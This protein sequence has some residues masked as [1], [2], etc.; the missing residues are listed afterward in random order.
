MCLLPGSGAV[1]NVCKQQR[2][3]SA[4]PRSRVGF[5][6][7]LSESNGF[8]STS[9]LGK[10]CIAAGLNES[11]GFAHGWRPADVITVNYDDAQI[12]SFGC[13]VVRAVGLVLLARPTAGRVFRQ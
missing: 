8:D 2:K 4:W 9:K 1:L 12:N 5:S 6:D 10:V 11:Q 3:A 13:P 7:E